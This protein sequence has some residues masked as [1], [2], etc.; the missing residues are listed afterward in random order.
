MTL[1]AEPRVEQN[2]LVLR[3]P[4][5]FERRGGRKRIV[6][7]DG[8]AIARSS[9]QAPGVKQGSATASTY[10][11]MLSGDARSPC[12][13]PI[14]DGPGT[15]RKLS[16][17]EPSRTS[18]QVDEVTVQAD[19]AETEQRAK[20]R[21]A[22]RRQALNLHIRGTA[23]K[24][25]GVPGSVDTLLPQPVVGRLRAIAACDSDRP[26]AGLSLENRKKIVDPQ[27]DRLDLASLHVS[28]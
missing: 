8:S 3:I 2:T 9:K 16:G 4:M 24:V 1:S 28:H 10:P 18:V 7:P 11:L 6:A 14:R 12:P 17:P 19:A 13:A 26:P 21:D 23:A 22:C 25:K 20:H 27:V 5:R 15:A